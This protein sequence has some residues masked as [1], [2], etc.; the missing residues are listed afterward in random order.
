MV[1]RVKPR[2]YSVKSV[3]AI[4]AT[5]NDEGLPGDKRRIVACQKKYGACNVARF[6]KSLDCCSQVARF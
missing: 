3:D 2:P 4:L 6:S 5:I 1:A